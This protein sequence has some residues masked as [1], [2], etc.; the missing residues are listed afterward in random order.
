ML[1]EWLRS[2]GGM[3]LKGENWSVVWEKLYSVGG[4]CMNVYRAFV[5][6]I[7][8][9]EFWSFG[10][11]YF[12]VCVLCEFLWSVD[13]MVMTGENWSAVRG[14][15]YRVGG[16]EINVYGEFVEWYW[17]GTV[18]TWRKKLYNC[19]VGECVLSNGAILLTLENWSFGRE[20]F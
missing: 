9:V 6:L 20:T 14:K 15:L 10:K 17:K 1:N 13:G 11:K 5:E 7:L 12:K 16:K 19:F 4:G 8:T 2:V 3:V 18:I